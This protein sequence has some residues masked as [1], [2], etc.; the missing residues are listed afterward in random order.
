MEKR[1]F[2]CNKLYHYGVVGRS[3]A[4]LEF[5]LRGRIQRIDING[6]RSSET[7]VN[8]GVPQCSVLGPF[9]FLVYMNDLPHLVKDGHGIALFADDTSLL[10]KIN[11]E[12]PAFHAVN[13]TIS[14]RVERLSIDILLLN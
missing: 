12:Q 8:M 11:G 7:T 4:L 13:S 14:E 1:F 5:Y 3:L 10:S 9:L 6:E 2:K